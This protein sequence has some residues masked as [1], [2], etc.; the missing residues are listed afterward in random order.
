MRLQFILQ[1]VYWWGHRARRV[2]ESRTKNGSTSMNKG[3]RKPVRLRAAGILL[4]LLFSCLSAP[5]TLAFD[6]SDVCSMACC[7]QEGHCCC[8]PRRARVQGRDSGGLNQIGNADVS[9]PCPEGCATSPTSSPS[10]FRDATRAAATQID[11]VAPEFVQSHTPLLTTRANT[12]GASS[13]RAP[14]SFLLHQTA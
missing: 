4:A 12:S 3:G 5:L 14:P 10:P 11:R 8:N 9:A 2:R 7:V 1:G 6:S 13:P